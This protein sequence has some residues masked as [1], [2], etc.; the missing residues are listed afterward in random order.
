MVRDD[1]GYSNCQGK[2]L[3]RRVWLMFGRFHFHVILCW[4]GFCEMYFPKQQDLSFSSEIALQTPCK[5]HWQPQRSHLTL[6][7]RGAHVALETLLRC[8]GDPTALFSEHRTTALVVCMLKLR[9]VGRRSRRSQRVYWR[10][11]CVAAAMLAILLRAPRR[12]WAPWDRAASV[13]GV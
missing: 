12:S 7:A 13:T 6:R 10:C 2:L 11:H 1:S 4:V 8:Y 5:R 3:L 9:A